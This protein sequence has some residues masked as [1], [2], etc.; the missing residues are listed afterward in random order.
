MVYERGAGQPVAIYDGWGNILDTLEVPPAICSEYFGN[1]GIHI[2][3]R[4]DVWGDGRQ[5]VI[6]AGWKGLRI[7]ANARPLPRDVAGGLRLTVEHRPP[8][9]A[10]PAEP[11][12]VTLRW[13]QLRTQTDRQGGSCMGVRRRFC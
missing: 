1:P 11:V 12:P 2:C 7:Y 4:A 8:A 6:L 10:Q 5:E 13:A 3:Y 9:G